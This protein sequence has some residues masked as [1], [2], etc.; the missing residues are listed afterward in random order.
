MRSPASPAFAKLIL[1]VRLDDGVNVWINGKLAYQE[2]VAS[3]E[4][5]YNG[6]ATAN[7]EEWTFGRHDLGAPATWLVRGTNVIAVQVLNVS[8]SD[9]SDCFVDVRLTGEKTQTVARQQPPCD[10]GVPARAGQV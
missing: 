9:S 4:M 6:L 2:N 5:P 3:A 8:L 7:I 10:A 1:E